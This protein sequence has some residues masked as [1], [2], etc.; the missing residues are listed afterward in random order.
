MT[1]DIDALNNKNS[2]LSDSV[3]KYNVKVLELK[4]GSEVARDVGPLKYISDLTGTPMNKVVNY[5]ILL[6]IFVFDP[7]AIALILA[8]N[9]AF[10]IER[11]G[12]LVY[13]PKPAPKPI[14]P[15]DLPSEPID[16]PEEPEIDYEEPEVELSGATEDKKEPVIPTG[17]IEV[18]DIKEIKENRKRGYS[19]PV[20]DPKNNTIER[21]GSNKIVKDGDRS[22]F[23]FKRNK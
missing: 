22:K 15:V 7:L 17:K 18:E 6:L 2:V 19:V 5:L 12:D 4:S 10:D 16:V 9:R 1:D 14:K 11:N 20:P 23:F 3:N 13:N 8:T 21:I